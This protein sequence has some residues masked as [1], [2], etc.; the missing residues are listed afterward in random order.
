MKSSRSL[1][2]TD[3]DVHAETMRDRKFCRGC[4]A[5]MVVWNHI[6]VW[7][8]YARKW[9]TINHGLSVCRPC[10]LVGGHPLRRLQFSSRC[11]EFQCARV[12]VAGY[13]G[14]S[15]PSI[16]HATEKRRADH[17]RCL[18]FLRLSVQ[19]LSVG[20]TGRLDMEIIFY[21][22][23][24]TPVGGNVDARPVRRDLHGTDRYR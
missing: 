19:I 24:K 14:K 15:L 10:V 6:F 18:W 8:K 22:V 16:D 1:V 3:D 9:K 11:F 21:F 4:Y 5:R 13:S 20:V 7:D 23:F 17:V 12:S 2:D